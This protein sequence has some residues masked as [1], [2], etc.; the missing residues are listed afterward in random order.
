MP[1]LCGLDRSGTPDPKERKAGRE[2]Y[3]I[4]FAGVAVSKDELQ[5]ALSSVRH[6][7]GMPASREFHGRDCPEWVRAKFLRR[8]Q[9]LGLQVAVAAYEKAPQ[10]STTER[11]QSPTAT[12]SNA[13]LNLLEMFVQQ[14]QLNYLWCD[15][16][17]EGKTAQ[18]AFQA[19]AQKCHRTAWPNTRMKARHIASNDSDIVQVADML[20]YSFSRWFR[21]LI[22]D[23]EL[24]NCLNEISK[25]T[26]NIVLGP[27][28]WG[29]WE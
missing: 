27:L 26:G 5:V 4:G 20:V 9:T 19:A 23:A 3:V 28:R 22:E 12:Q 8:V 13:A 29:E 1:L 17:I 15:E 11:L 14:H 25:A 21:G 24:T 10:S 2:L 18:G 6:E 7:C 16:D